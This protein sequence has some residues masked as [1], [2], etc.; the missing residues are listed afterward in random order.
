MQILIT[1]PNGIYKAPLEDYRT[2]KQ[3]FR[4]EIFSSSPLS[5]HSYVS[6]DTASTIHDAVDFVVM[7]LPLTHP[8]FISTVTLPPH[9][10][11]QP[12]FICQFTKLNLVGIIISVI[13]VLSGMHRYFKSLL[14][15][16]VLTE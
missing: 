16:K 5:S 15:K 9:S 14:K 3:L 4:R 8:C 2:S 13:S 12:Q 10:F 1:I 11:K 6:L 7:R